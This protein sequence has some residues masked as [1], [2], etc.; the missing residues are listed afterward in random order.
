M[1]ILDYIKRLLLQGRIIFTLKAQ[2]EMYLDGLTDDDVVEAIVNAAA[3]Y[4]TLRSRSRRHRTRRERL[5]VIVGR[6]YDG[7]A[8]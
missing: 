2:T 7:V 3:I 8:I 4:K 1:D 5:Y 6:T